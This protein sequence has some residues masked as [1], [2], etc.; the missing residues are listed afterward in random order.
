VGGATAF[1]QGVYIGGNFSDVVGAVTVAPDQ[2]FDVTYRFR[3]DASTGG[4]RRQEVTA[5]V[6]TARLSANISYIF[7]SGVNPAIS[8]SGTAQE[9]YGT[10]TSQIDDNWSVFF[11]GRRDLE[12]N[13]NLTY[14]GGVN[15][16]NDCIS[17]SL[18]GSVNN[19]T[20]SSIQPSTSVMLTIG[21]KNLG[22]YGFSF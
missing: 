2:A 12:T 8:A 15:Y 11:A 6:G 19:Y 17:V 21:F 13:Q 14:G 1:D 9:I 20:Q 7:L 22:A 5:R 4:F 16:R 18:V 3:V 10:L